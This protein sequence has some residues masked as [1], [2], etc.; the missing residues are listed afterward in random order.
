MT[1]DSFP[2]E[3]TSLHNNILSMVEAH[4]NICKALICICWVMSI[5]HQSIE[6]QQQSM[7]SRVGLSLM[8]TKTLCNLLAGFTAFIICSRGTCMGHYYNLHNFKILHNCSM[9]KLCD[10]CTHGFKFKQMLTIVLKL[11]WNNRA[12]DEV[13]V[14]EQLRLD[15]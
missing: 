1:L 15:Q 9:W 13:G 5:V 10:W 2:I 3:C 8:R 12:C 14:Y 4:A 7:T 11:H 6:L